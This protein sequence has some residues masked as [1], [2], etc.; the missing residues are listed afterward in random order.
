MRSRSVRTAFTLTALVLSL[1]VGAAL[2]STA[3]DS[4]ATPLPM[5]EPSEVGMSAEGIAAHEAA[6]KK[7]VDEG[8]LPGVVSAIA[9]KGKLVHFSAYGKQDLEA[10]TPI[11]KDTI[12]RIFSMTKPVAGVA[13]MTFYDEGRFSLDDPV[14]K[15]I[16]QFKDLQVAKEDGP[17][18][19]PVTEPADHPMTIRELMSHTGGLTYGLFSRS[20]TDQLY[21]QNNVLDPFSTLKDM[22]DKLGELPLRQQPGTQWHYSVSVDVQGYLVEVLAGKPF[23]VVLKERIFDPLGMVDTDFGVPD[24]KVERFSKLYAPSREGLKEQQFGQYRPRP[25]LFSGGGGLVSTASDY[26]RFAQMLLNGGEL[27]G[28]RILKPETVK[29][30]HTNQLPEAV[31]FINPLIGNPGNTFGLDFALVDSPDGKADHE[32]A[33][34]E[35]WWYGIG[36][37][38]FGINPVQAHVR[39]APRQPE[40][41]SGRDPFQRLEQQ[42]NTVRD[43]HQAEPD[44]PDDKLLSDN[45]P[46]DKR[47][48]RLQAVARA[49]CHQR[50]VGRAGRADL[51]DGKN[52][53]CTCCDGHLTGLSNTETKKDR[54]SADPLIS[55][56]YA[57]SAYSA[58][59]ATGRTDTKVRPLKPLRKVTLPSAVANR[60]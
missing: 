17:D 8:K 25:T 53:K 41:I 42:G 12:F 16:P 39:D 45:D 32:L 6:M 46:R 43:T 14:E 33:K 2:A 56:T 4:P 28:K 19:K 5:A 52:Q 37:T 44:R 22:V 30:M 49:G 18:G 21:V 55:I 23:D 26:L 51:A 58:A 60:V 13:L 47:Q 34:G 20:Q 50:H 36:G 24:D 1:A 54:R 38:W 11:T 29:L 57:G 35:Y 59:S 15:F 3:A 31:E 48:R 27:D 9:R 40:N 7:F 10:G